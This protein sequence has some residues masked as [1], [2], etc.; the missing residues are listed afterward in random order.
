M[1]FPA[2][3]GGS[4][5]TSY[6]CT[7]VPSG[8]YCSLNGGSVNN[9][10]STNVYLYNAPTVVPYTV[11]IYAINNVGNGVSLAETMCNIHNPLHIIFSFA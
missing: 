1:S 8:G 5:I 4:S 6:G 2:S 10:Y 11:N 9:F 7:T 3:N